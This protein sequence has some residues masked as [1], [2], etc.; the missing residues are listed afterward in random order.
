MSFAVFAALRLVVKAIGVSYIYIDI[1]R[2]SRLR[3]M[4]PKNFL[5]LAL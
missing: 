2:D 3:L 5:S 4:R 1:L